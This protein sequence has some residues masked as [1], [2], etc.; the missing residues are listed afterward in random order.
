MLAAPPARRLG[1][2]LDSATRKKVVARLPIKPHHM[3]RGQR[4]NGGVLM[5]FADFLGA[6]GTVMNL[7]PGWRTTTIESKTNFFVAGEGPVLTGVSTPLHVGRSTNVWQTRVT[8][9]DGRMVALITQTQIVLPP[10]VA[11]SRPAGA[12]SA[13]GK[14]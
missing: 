14:L 1:I 3:N 4:V 6:A 10:P 13:R 12:P 7:V 11:G 9:A 2:E 5:A 8:N